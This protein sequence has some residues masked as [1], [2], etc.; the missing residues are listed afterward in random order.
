M[1]TLLFD[2]RCL[3]LFFTL[4]Q[5]VSLYTIYPFDD[6]QSYLLSS[7]F[8]DQL[9]LP[10][11][12]K[13]SVFEDILINAIN[14]ENKDTVEELKAQSKRSTPRIGLSS[15]PQRRNNR[16]HWNPLVAAYKRC[17]ELVS[18]EKR[19]NCFKDAVQMLFVHK[20]RK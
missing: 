16:P 2:V 11:Q 10:I 20:L 15:I 18:T 8:K 14:N 5:S 17:G 6:D 4:V 13:H 1:V 9:N 19:E 7:S 3:L 12:T